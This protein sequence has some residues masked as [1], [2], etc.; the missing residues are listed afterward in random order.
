MG[1]IFVAGVFAVGK[2]TLCKQAEQALGLPH[3]SASGLIKAEKASA[4]SSQDKAVHNV[5]DNQQLLIR[6]A[7]KALA[8]HEGNILLDG[9]FSLPT[10]D[11]RI[12]PVAIE[13]FHALGLLRAIVLSDE[14]EA[15]ASRW[16][17]RDGQTNKVESIHAHQE[18]ELRHAR[19][20][21]QALAIP[22][23][24]IQAFDLTTFLDSL[25]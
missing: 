24:Q 11:G 16:Q 1:V 8:R 18:I 12:E 2:T 15:I 7:E 13:V 3:Y 6:G 4:I 5:A 19:D 23:I 9:H 17:G 21:A 10:T 20:V 25:A 22:L 14:P